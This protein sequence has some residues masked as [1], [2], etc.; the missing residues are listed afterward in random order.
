MS[1]SA[2]IVIEGKKYL[3]KRRDY[4]VAITHDAVAGSTAQGTIQVDPSSPFIWD[5]VHMVDTNDPTLV[6]PGLQGQYENFISLQ[7]QANNYNFSNDFVPRSAFARDR[8]RGFRLKTEILIE[9]N[10]RFVINIKNPAAGAAAGTTYVT[11][12]GYALF[13]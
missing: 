9:R 4:V 5:E 13:S 2:T 8:T 12:Q 11:L 3:K 10:T 6:A 7:D 1:N